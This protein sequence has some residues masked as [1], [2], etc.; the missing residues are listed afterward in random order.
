MPFRSTPLRSSANAAVL[1]R[2]PLLAHMHRP[3]R[4]PVAALPWLFVAGDIA[5]IVA[6]AVGTEQLYHRFITDGGADGQRSIGLALV[7]AMLFV[8]L[9]QSQKLYQAIR[10]VRLVHHTRQALVNWISVFAALAGLMFLLKLG[11]AFSRVS[12][13]AFFCSGFT[14]LMAWRMALKRLYLRFVVAGSLTGPRVA[15]LVE[16]GCPDIGSQ[17]HKLRRSGYRVSRLFFLPRETTEGERDPDA[18]DAALRGLQRHVRERHVDEI[19]VLASWRCFAA[20]DDIQAA[21]RMV[22]VPVKLVADPRLSRLLSYRSCEVATG[23]AILLKPAALDRLQRLRKRLFDIAAASFLLVLL[24]PLLALLALAIRLDSSGPVLFRQWRGGFNHRRFRICKFRTMHVLEDGSAIRQASRND[25]RVTRIGRWLRST[26]L[27]EL[28]QLFN[29][30]TGDMSLVGPRPHAIAHDLAYSE[31]IGPYPAR[32][33]V[34]PGITGWAQ[35]NG[36]RGETAD[37]NQMKR[38][39][40]HDLTYIQNWSLFMDIAIIAMTVREVIKPRNAY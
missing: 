4:F 39:I 24:M 12:F 32:H 19:L 33:N 31:L 23:R 10:S 30:L 27:D 3:L 38:R 37:V 6:A 29:V 26:S 40:E 34:K 35:V 5:V 9:Q 7:A 1:P 14:G 11:E 13:I 2:S 36:A 28:P 21:L 18:T 22:P 20:C 25:R 15:L 8:A 17:L 16:H